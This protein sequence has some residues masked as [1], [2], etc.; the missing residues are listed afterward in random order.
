[1]SLDLFHIDYGYISQFN[2]FQR[3]AKA[4][5]SGVF[6]MIYKFQESLHFF[7]PEIKWPQELQVR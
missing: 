4:G 3:Y 5:I 2:A 7:C 1:M 6:Q